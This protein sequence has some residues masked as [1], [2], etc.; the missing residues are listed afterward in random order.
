LLE[1]IVLLLDE[2]SENLMIT[3]EMRVER[4]T[5]NKVVY[6]STKRIIEVFNFRTQKM[7]TIHCLMLLHGKVLLLNLLWF[8]HA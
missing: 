8:C 5:I 6:W 3:S 7:K 2:N 4:Q 1:V